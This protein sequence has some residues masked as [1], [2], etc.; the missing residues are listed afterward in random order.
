MKPEELIELSKYHVGR[1]VR[2]LKLKWCT[3]FHAD[4]KYRY[5]MGWSLPSGHHPVVCDKCKTIK[6]V[7][8]KGEFYQW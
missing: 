4:I 5:F 6:Y 1:I 3:R 8:G 2:R 7:N